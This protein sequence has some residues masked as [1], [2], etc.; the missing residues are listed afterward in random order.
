MSLPKPIPF[1]P[2]TQLSAD[3]LTGAVVIEV[4]DI[5]FFPTLGAGEYTYVTQSDDIG[6]TSND[7]ADY[8]TIKISAVT[9]TGGGAGELTIDARESEGTMRDP[10]PAGTYISCRIT[11]VGTDDMINQI[12]FGNWDGGEPGTNYGGFAAIDGGGV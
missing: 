3:L 9:A 1:S 7:P 2:V 10:W 8:E 5:A 6:Y 4:D 12:V 11:A